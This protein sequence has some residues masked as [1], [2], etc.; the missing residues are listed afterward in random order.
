MIFEIGQTLVYP[1][2][3]A[4]TITDV[5]VRS[6]RGVD[7]TYVTLAVHTSDLVISLPATSIEAVGLRDVID[8]DGVVAV[9]SVLRA[10]G[11]DEST[12][13]TRRFKA[14]QEKMASGNVYAISEVVRDLF[15]RQERSG[16]SS[17]EK[18][19]LIQARRVVVA[20]LALARQTSETAA[21]IELDAVLVDVVSG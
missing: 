15:L 16:L 4:A 7:T 10:G 14:N 20:E 2:H 6:V 18:A 11:T 5:A 13:W 21:A 1:H 3:G 12:N 19:M 17:G 9:Y 8:G